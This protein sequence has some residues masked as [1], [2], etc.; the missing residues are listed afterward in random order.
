[1][2]I[3]SL[4]GYNNVDEIVQPVDNKGGIY[5]GNIDFA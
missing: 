2:N 1:M 3:F 4:L 5:I